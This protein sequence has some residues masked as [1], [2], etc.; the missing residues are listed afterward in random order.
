[1][2]YSMFFLLVISAFLMIP[3]SGE[4]AQ[5]LVLYL[6]FDNDSGNA[7]TDQSS[8]NNGATFQGNPQWI[9]GKFGQALQFDGQTWGEVPDDPSLDLTDAM[10]IE[11]WALVEPGGEAI[12][13]AVEKG[14]SWKDGEYNLAA[15][16]NGGSLLQA[17]DLPADCADTNVGSSIQDGEWHFLAGTWDGSAIKLYIDGAPDAE[18][19]CAGTL[20][21]N[22]DPLFIGARG[23]T[24]RFLTGALDEIKIYNYAL[25]GDMIL[26]D[27]DNPNPTAVDAK[28]K[29][30]ATWGAIKASF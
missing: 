21:T 30:A 25:D 16:Y 7:A 19:P 1:M 2:K 12:Q 3:L 14:D 15:L 20:L 6:S 11:V 23:G 26:R 27:M 10:T 29:L 5:D 13:S 9:S 22:D 18:T 28:G 8:F 24:G 17:H 4:S